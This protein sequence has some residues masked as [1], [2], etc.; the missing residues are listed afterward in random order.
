MLLYIFSFYLPSNGASVQSSFFQVS[1]Q[2]VLEQL[3]SDSMVP[4]LACTHVVSSEEA[5]SGVPQVLTQLLVQL[6]QL[7]QSVCVSGWSLVGD[8]CLH[9]NTLN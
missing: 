4:E 6:L 9:G 7:T 1:L 2:S 3:C 8:P 5:V